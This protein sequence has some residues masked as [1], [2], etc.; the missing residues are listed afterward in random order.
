MNEKTDK[1][2]ETTA[3]TRQ[4]KAERPDP[5]TGR[6]VG[7]AKKTRAEGPKV[8][9][10][11]TVRGVAKQYTVYTGGVPEELEAFFKAHRAAETLLVPVEKFAETRR[12][13]ETPG[14]AENMVYRK[15][16]SEL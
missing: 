1:D 9:C 10:G 16:K 15:V 7:K 8:Y 14:T 2:Q 4:E 12:K 13:L 5:E 6:S 3:Q 11:P